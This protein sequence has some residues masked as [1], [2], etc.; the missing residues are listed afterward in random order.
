MRPA[1]N[2]RGTKELR[3]PPRSETTMLRCSVAVEVARDCVPRCV[4]LVRPPPTGRAELN[5]P[6][7]S[8]RPVGGGR[9]ERIWSSIEVGCGGHRNLG[10]PRPQGRWVAQG[11]S[12]AQRLRAMVIG[13][14]TL[15]VSF[16][17][18]PC[19]RGSPRLPKLGW[20]FRDLLCGAPPRVNLLAIAF[21]VSL[22]FSLGGGNSA[23]TEPTCVCRR[24]YPR[25][26]RVND[27]GPR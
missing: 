21:P 8:A 19:G 20:W 9:R 3:C 13:G 6:E 4:V 16:T 7:S 1:H 23:G 5:R 11:Q 12:I 15:I 27:S 26:A 17:R 14:Q 2:E 25:Q 22:F 24:N 18:R 10:E